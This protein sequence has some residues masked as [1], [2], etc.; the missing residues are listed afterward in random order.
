MILDRAFSV[1]AHSFIVVFLRKCLARSLAPRS[2]HDVTQKCLRP[3]VSGM[4][5]AVC[6][7]G[8]GWLSFILLSLLFS[9]SR[10]QPLGQNPPR[11]PEVPFSQHAHGAVLSCLEENLMFLNQ[12]PKTIKE[13][14]LKIGKTSKICSASNQD[15]K[16][17]V[18]KMIDKYGSAL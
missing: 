8:M 17:Y 3:R 4:E 1:A 18:G 10:E 14:V 2:M 13:F 16:T 12:K 6:G 11:S 7:R 15:I 5:G 9:C